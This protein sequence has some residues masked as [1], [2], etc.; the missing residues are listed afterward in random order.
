MIRSRI[1]FL[2]TLICILFLNAC[3]QSRV[4][5]KN[6]AIGNNGWAYGQPLQF[7]V[8]VIDTTESYNMFIN[9]RHTDEY[10]YNNLWINLTTI[11]PDSSIVS[12]K[13]NVELSMPDGKWT[14][15]C[16]DGICY[17]AVLIQKNFRMPQKGKYTFILDQDM[18]MNP[19]PGLL[20]V[21]IR[22]EKFIE[23]HN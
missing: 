8:S 11:L 6:I 14:G 10:P 4:F 16:V 1:I 21:G 13:V 23:L 12:S 18:R 5:D 3:E 20:D 22:V 17:N 19:V 7:E 9:I 15:N 2:T